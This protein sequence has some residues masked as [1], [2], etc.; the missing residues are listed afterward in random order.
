MRYMIQVLR[1]MNTTE[2]RRM[3]SSLSNNRLSENSW[4]T[5]PTMPGWS[6][7]LQSGYFAKVQ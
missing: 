6:K 5:Q 7:W 4:M 1:V 2:A 3:K